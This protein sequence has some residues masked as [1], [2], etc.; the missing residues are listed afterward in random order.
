[1]I[2]QMLHTSESENTTSHYIIFP[3]GINKQCTVSM[4]NHTCA[5]DTGRVLVG[6]AIW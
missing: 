5:L 2:T 3:S 1:M 4:Y 6:P